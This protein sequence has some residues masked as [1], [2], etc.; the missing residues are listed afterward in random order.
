MNRSI[1]ARIA[2]EIVSNSPFFT[3]V[4]REWIFSGGMRIVTRSD[5]GGIAGASCVRRL[6]PFRLTSEWRRRYLKVCR[7]DRLG[8]VR[9]EPNSHRADLLQDADE[10]VEQLLLH[11]LAVL[12]VRDRAEVHA[13][14]LPRGLDETSFGLEGPLERAGVLGDGARPVALAQHDAVRA[15]TDAVVREGLGVFLRLLDVV[16]AAS[17]WRPSARPGPRHVGRM[18]PTDLFPVLRVPRIVE[19]YHPVQVLLPPSLLAVASH[20][21]AVPHSAKGK[22]HEESF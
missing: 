7:S 3:R 15:V 2:S 20:R 19:L 21:H 8:T 22:S 11:D 13:E 10:V 5:S 18:K 6:W 9:V 4:W 14:P 1:A 12:P 16:G 17:G